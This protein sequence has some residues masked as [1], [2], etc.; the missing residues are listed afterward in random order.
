MLST[1]NLGYR[2]NPKGDIISHLLF[3]GN[4]ELC[5]VRNIQLASMMKIVNK[6]SDN[7]TISFR[8]DKFKKLSMPVTM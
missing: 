1:S 6:F 8:I 7:I 5:A 2:I 4:L 3:M